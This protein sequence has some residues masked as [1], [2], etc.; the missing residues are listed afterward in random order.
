MKH[1]SPGI[2]FRVLPVI[3]ALVLAGCGGGADSSSKKA[4]I[5]LLNL[6]SGYD[7]IDLYSKNA[8]DDADVKQFTAI[9]TGAISAY[10]ALKGDSYTLKFRKTGTSGDLLS[11]AATLASDT[12]ATFVA[13]GATGEFSVAAIDD[14]IEVPATGYTKVQVLNTA[15]ENFD[16]YL[17]GANDALADVSATVGAVASGAQSTATTM[18][19]GSYRLRVTATG[20][21]SDLR[22]NVPEISLPTAGV[23]SIILTRSTGGVLVNAVLLPKQGQPTAYDN[24]ATA[25]IRV[26]NVTSGYDALDVYTSSEGSDADTQL[27]AAIARGSATSYAALKADTYTF[28]FR[29]S[30]AAGNLL[31]L[32][33]TLAE[34]K[35][36]TYVAYGSSGRFGVFAVDEETELASSSY[37]KLQVFNGTAADN[38]DVYLTGTA[39]A[40]TDV[41]PAISA[42]AAGT[43]SGFTTIRSGSYRLRITAAGSKVDVR[44]DVPSMTANSTGVMSLV[45]TESAGGVLVSAVLL[46]QQGA[47]VKYDNNTVRLRGATGLTAGAL[48]TINVAG[49]EIVTRRSA[50]S[51]IADSYTTLASGTVPVVVYVDNVAVVSGTVTLDAGT[52]YTLLAWD[53]GGGAMQIALIADDNHASATHRAKLRLLDGMSGVAVP[54]T[55]AVGYSPIAEYI[56]AGTASASSELPAGTDNRLDI[57]NAQTLAPLLARESVTLL[58]D[59]VYTF[60]VAG[61][62][63]SALT[64]T[65]RKDR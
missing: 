1:P 8:D 62:G 64:G 23:V 25:N 33:S 27:F 2:L 22:L 28:K 52:D 4:Q 24:T 3:L 26:L 30:G 47:P 45:L 50:R 10:S 43:S 29:K 21:K 53:G 16:V 5:R 19:S 44:L 55:L 31:S 65:L 9:T 48:A 59:G 38:L 58:A 40:L 34:D 35:H 60:F 6:S 63:S 32:T 13:Y 42:V 14:D 37:T 20:S 17:T 49:T 54:L 46:P 39:D 7:S 41:S 18:S 15:S 36:A 12:H 57:S 56:E 11:R 51:F 61:G